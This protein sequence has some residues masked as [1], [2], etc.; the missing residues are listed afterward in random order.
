M[1]RLIL[2][3]LCLA[4]ACPVAA[5]S[6]SKDDA[7]KKV[8]SIEATDAKVLSLVPTLQPVVD[9]VEVD[10]KR[11]VPELA[12][13]PTFCVCAAAVTMELWRSGIDPAMKNRIISYATSPANVEDFLKYEGPELY[14]PLC[15]LAEPE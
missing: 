15:E 12:K 8:A 4:T 7:R 10:C 6:I 5:D 14:R 11:R 1:K 3:L 9:L 13:S 2:I